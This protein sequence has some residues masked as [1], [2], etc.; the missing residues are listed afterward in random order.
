MAMARNIPI[1]LPIA[2]R[3]ALLPL[4]L[5]F[6]AR[7]QHKVDFQA[8]IQ[9]IFEKS[10][11]S[12][13][14]AKAQRG[15]LRL[16]SEA[17]AMAG[18]Q[19]GKVIIP[20]NARDSILYQ[21]VAGLG[22]QARMPMGGTLSADQIETIRNWIDQGTAT[23][24]AAPTKKH[25][26]F[27]APVRPQVP[28]VQQVN[29]V[30]NPIDA[31]I[32]ERLETEKLA[33][34]PEADRTTLLRRLSLDLVGLP[35]TPEEIDAFINDR[36]PKAY[37]KQ[38]DR[39]L[40]SP[41]Y[42]ERW[43]RVWLDAARY[44]DSDGFEKDKARQVWFYR[45]WVIN[46]MNR[47]L[48]YDR[49][50]IRQIAG[51]QLPNATQDDR[52]ATGF[53]RNS[54]LNEEGGIDPEQ[55][56]M[57][58]LFDRMEAIGKGVLGIT[59]QCAQC[60]THKF[61]PIKHEDYYRMLA[62]LNDS[63]EANA[64]VYTP[65]DQMKIAEILRRTNELEGGLRHRTSDWEAQMAA[66]EKA[67]MGTQPQWTTLSFPDEELSSGGQKLIR[68][69]DGSFLA[70]GD[71]GINNNQKF[72]A[73]TKL[74]K[75]TAIQ[76]EMLTDANL[77]RGGP[78]RGVNGMFGLTEF[79]VEAK[80]LNADAAVKPVKMKIVSATAD[81]NPPETPLAAPLQSKG[82]PVKVTGPIEFA[83]DGKNTTAWGVDVGPGLRNQ[84]RKAVFRFAEPIAIP[85]GATLIVNLNQSHGGGDF[86]NNNLGRFRISVTDAPAAIADP[87]PKAVR[88]ILAIPHEQRS[89]A[90]IQ[91]VFRYWR[92]TV[93]A[94]SQTNEEIAALWRDYPEGNSQL[95]VQLRESP[96]QTHILTRG[97]YSKPAAEVQPGVPA[98]LN[99]LPAGAPVNRLTFAKWM[100]SRDSPTTARSYVNRVWQNFFGIGIV[101]TSEDL[102]TQSETPSH[103]ELLDWLA[104]EFMENGWSMKKLSRA[105][106]L[107]SIYRQSSHVTPDLYARDPYNRLLARG[108]RFR[109]DAEVVRDIALAA[110]GLLNPAVGGPSVYP[111]APDFLFHRPVS[112][113]NKDWF[114]SEGSDRYRRALY[115][116]RYR[117][118]PYPMLQTFDAPSGENSCVR[119]AR[120]NT[121]LQALTMLNEPLF[122]EAAR[123]LATRTLRDGGEDD[124]QRMRYAFRRCLGRVPS[125]SETDELLSLLKKEER[126]FTE[127]GRDAAQFSGT[128]DSTKAAWTAVAR[129]L[130]NLDETIT[131]E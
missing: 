27:I 105:I 4:I 74:E 112:Y 120:S 21:R 36:S 49:F 85:G 32:L 6:G 111:P 98:F 96:R 64:A 10:C 45:D 37:E 84:P 61:D 81:V 2:L 50:V 101:A 44:A 116:F 23:S 24:S 71:P 113:S 109:V 53:L 122:L 12:C 67:Q 69:D 29:W 30:S 51:D 129:V 78:G 3:I 58:S 25:W 28:K 15:R 19:S 118:V 95:L 88:D 127:F 82:K 55:F 62:F 52:V 11:G 99:S 121:P 56:R 87:L 83:I 75:I 130:L 126:R 86:Y 1:A 91:I 54:M 39:L 9:P 40:A 80:P 124:T 42:G 41:H 104:V 7:A 115:T 103:R 100:V 110:S 131:K 18:G 26:A 13:H 57:E 117:S 76:L 31:F 59:V 8:D 89:P 92:T 34:S 5:S 125:G 102:G 77:P 123:E 17:A 93:P 107:S 43:A 20:G 73:K 70:Q 68:M 48:P 38:V 94:W 119:R 63:D 90:Q 46:A 16:D 65:K 79:A 72:T 108:P 47:D 14:S 60:H 33:P 114:T 22:D 35:P 66:W 97:D 106:V 128:A